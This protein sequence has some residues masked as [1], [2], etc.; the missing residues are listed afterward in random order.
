MKAD[1][2]E[3][4]LEALRSGRYQQGRYRLC[5]DKAG[6]LTHCCLGVL[7][8]VMGLE[9]EEVPG[10]RGYVMDGRPRGLRP[11]DAVLAELGITDDHLDEL[12]GMNDGLDQPGCDFEEIADYIE[13]NL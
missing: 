9:S 11:P 6:K 4:W 8:E 12:V 5:T 3:K 10:G 7:C 1:I 13:E 2:K